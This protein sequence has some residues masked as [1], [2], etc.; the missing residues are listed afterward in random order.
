MKIPK[1]IVEDVLV[2][3]DKLYYP[4]D[5][6]ILDIKPEAMGANY[7]PIILGRPFFATS[8]AIINCWNGVMQLIFGNMTLELNIFHSS[9]KHA[10]LKEE[11]SEEVCLIGTSVGEHC[12]R[13]LKGELMESLEKFD[14]ELSTPPITQVAPP[15]PPEPPNKA[16]HLSLSLQQSSHRITSS[17]TCSSS[18]HSSSSCNR[19]NSSPTSCSSFNSCS[20]TR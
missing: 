6:F 10:N 9:N 7:V 4:V 11:G 8:N 1:G 20:I 16:C 12:A 13:K 5:F 19:F 2:K 3:V 15:I 18:G 14:E 17:T